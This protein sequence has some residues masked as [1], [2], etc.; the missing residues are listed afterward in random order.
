MGRQARRV[1][2]TEVLFWLLATCGVSEVEESAPADAR[3]RAALE[4]LY[5]AT[6]GATG[7]QTVS[8]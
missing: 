7:S 4:A 3:E 6:D 8:G 2:E 5:R 1:V